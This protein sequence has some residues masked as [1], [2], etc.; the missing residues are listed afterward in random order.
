VHFPVF[1]EEFF[2]IF[3]IFR[4]K[5]AEAL[6]KEKNKSLIFRKEIMHYSGKHTNVAS[7]PLDFQVL[8]SFFTRLKIQR[9]TGFSVW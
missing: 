9:A 6:T 3:P 4:A 7:G 8:L 2:Q 5:N 1:Y